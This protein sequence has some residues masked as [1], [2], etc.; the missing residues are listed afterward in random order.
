MLL[1]AV[2]RYQKINEPFTFNYSNIMEKEKIDNVF[3]IKDLYFFGYLS[4]K[5]LHS[6]GKSNMLI[7]ALRYLVIFFTCCNIFELKSLL[8][9]V[10]K[11]YIV[12]I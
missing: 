8:Q 7:L 12:Q 5:Y 11:Y 10:K 2:C 3:G 4:A 6:Y 9:N 1:W